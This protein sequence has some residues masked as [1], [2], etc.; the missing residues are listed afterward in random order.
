MEPPAAHAPASATAY[1]HLDIDIRDRDAIM[2]VFARYGSDIG[3]VVHTAAQPSHDWAAGDPFTDFDVNAVGTLNVLQAA[4]DAQPDRPVHLHLDQQGLRRPA[5]HAAAGRAGHPLGD[6]AGSH[7]RGRHPRG[8]VDRRLPAQRVRRVEGGRRRDGAGVRPLLRHAHRLLP[9]RH[10]DRPAALGREAARLPR[11]RD[12]LRDDPHPVH[13]LRLRRQAGP[14]RH[15]LE[16]P[17]QRVRPVLAGAAGG[18]GLQHRRRPVQQLLG[19]RGDRPSRRRSPASRWSGATPRPTAPAT[20]SG[21][22]ATTAASP[23]TIRSGRSTHDVEAILTE[24]HEANAE[25]WS[26]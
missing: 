11:L 17:D 13:G 3:L 15:P 1:R 7:L 8:H 25:R 22:S 21:G 9:R 10:P 2:D 20:T 19:A 14:R 12:A 23:S 4:R 18:R 5:E 24:M 16:G 26:A 6:R